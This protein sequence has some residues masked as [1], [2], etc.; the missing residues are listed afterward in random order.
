M[1]PV[2]DMTV[3]PRTPRRWST[4]DADLEDAARLL[5]Q[6]AVVVAPT[7]S[8]Y[9]L[10][11]SPSHPGAVACIRRLKSRDESLGKPLLLLCASIDQA[12]S[13]GI[14]DE[15]AERLATA[16]PAPLTLVLP[17]RDAALARALGSDGLALRVPGNAVARRLAELA[18]PFTGTSAN[19]VG[20]PPIL[21]P[22][23][24]ARLCLRSGLAGVVD[25]GLLPGGPPST[26]VDVRDRRIV[27]LR[28]GAFPAA[29]L[30]A[31]TS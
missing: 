12:R 31:L 24:A 23:E 18:G 21:D 11:S 29:S 6:G 16:W 14:F 25:A 27:I 8:S 10:A 9:C 1:N 17:A 19:L 22:G 26:L 7:E 30:A 15:M 2:E 20:E 4:T 5:V 28:Q 13:V 3:N